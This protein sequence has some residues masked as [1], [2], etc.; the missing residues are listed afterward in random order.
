MQ[1][2]VG[3]LLTARVFEELAAAGVQRVDLGE[4]GQEHN[5]RLGCQMGDEGTVHVYSPTLRGVWL[6]LFFLEPRRSSGR[7]AAELSR[8]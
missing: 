4:G 3:S 5:R 6:S 1:F 2:S 8:D 7:S